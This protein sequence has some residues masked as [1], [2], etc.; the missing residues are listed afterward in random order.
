MKKIIDKINAWSLYYRTEIVWFVLALLWSYIMKK[1][2]TISGWAI[3]ATW[4]DGTEETITE[5]DDDTAGYV[6]SF[7]NDYE[8]EQDED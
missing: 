7:L 1:K 2:K 5:I 6:D 3:I 4:S 8:S